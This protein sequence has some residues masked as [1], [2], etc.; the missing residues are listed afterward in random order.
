M[1]L[2]G[3]W[4]L[5]F[6]ATICEEKGDDW[7]SGALTGKKSSITPDSILRYTVETHTHIRVLR[8]ELFVAA[9]ACFPSPFF[10]CSFVAVVESSFNK[11]STADEQTNRTSY[12]GRE[13]RERRD[14]TT[15]VGPSSRRLYF[16]PKKCGKMWW[17]TTWQT[18]RREAGHYVDKK[19]RIESKEEEALG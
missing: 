2:Y 10:P 6:G 3:K 9:A 13:G 4:L 12:I 16:F 7:S 11:F 14:L 1:T 5:S 18:A 8:I 15:I 17:K 19:R